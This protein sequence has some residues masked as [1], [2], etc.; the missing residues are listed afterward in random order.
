VLGDLIIVDAV[1]FLITEYPVKPYRGLIV[2]MFSSLIA[3][4]AI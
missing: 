2:A 4:R 1:S 3:S